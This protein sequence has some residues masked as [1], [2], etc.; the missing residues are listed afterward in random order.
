MNLSQ[1]FPLF[2]N[3]KEAMTHL[4][5]NNIE[6]YINLSKTTN[7]VF[8]EPG[9]MIVHSILNNISYTFII[10]KQYVPSIID[11]V[12]GGMIKD[13]MFSNHI[14]TLLQYLD[15]SGEVVN[16]NVVNTTAINRMNINKAIK[17]NNI[18]KEEKEYIYSLVSSNQYPFEVYL[19]FP[20]GIKNNKLYKVISSF[21]FEPVESKNDRMDVLIYP[22]SNY[23]IINCLVSRIFE[24]I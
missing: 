9:D 20:Q 11:T 16:I 21:L 2:D 1:G 4:S 19:S 14:P 7:K 6:Y 17:S 3:I 8:P 18:S 15:L 12:N 22:Y 24:A 23:T 5:P 13:I 10:D